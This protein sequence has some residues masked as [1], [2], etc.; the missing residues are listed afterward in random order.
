MVEIVESGQ[1]TR[2]PENC[3]TCALALGSRVID[4][5]KQD[6]SR[7]PATLASMVWNPPKRVLL[8]SGAFFEG[9]DEAE[10]DR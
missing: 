10:R 2:L 4:G 3:S 7:V 8:D 6:G 5:P 9:V 1:E